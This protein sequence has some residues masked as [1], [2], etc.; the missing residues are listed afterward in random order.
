MYIHTKKPR[1]LLSSKTLS[2]LS[3]LSIADL[4]FSSAQIILFNVE[5]YLE[6]KNCKLPNDINTDSQLTVY[7][8]GISYIKLPVILKLNSGPALRLTSSFDY[9]LLMNVQEM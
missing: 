5:Y 6:Q 8:R 9:D 1:I 7:L 4:V 3:C 2:W